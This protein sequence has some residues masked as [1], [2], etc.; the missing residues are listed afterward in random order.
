MM[1]GEGET[2]LASM[3]GIDFLTI[4]GI[5]S[6]KVKTLNNWHRS[7]YV[8]RRWSLV[9]LCALYK[10]L[11]RNESVMKLENSFI[12]QLTYNDK[13]WRL[14]KQCRPD[15]R[16]KRSDSLLSR[17][18]MRFLLS[19]RAGVWVGM[20]FYFAKLSWSKTISFLVSTVIS[21]FC[22]GQTSYRTR[23]QSVFFHN[24]LCFV[25]TEDYHSL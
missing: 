19:S 23:I 6:L 17:L 14:M 25:I 24:S 3:Q 15:R 4:L 22:K 10:R 9:I 20:S 7:T 5:L 21:D 11:T 8:T 18:K 16:N 12:K 1:F 2:R 13:L